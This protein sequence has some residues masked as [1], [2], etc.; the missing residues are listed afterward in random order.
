MSRQGLL[1]DGSSDCP[2]KMRDGSDPTS[3]IGA[4]DA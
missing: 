4:V 2:A 3:G 1:E